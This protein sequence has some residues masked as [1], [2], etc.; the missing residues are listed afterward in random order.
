MPTTSV[1]RPT[2][3]LKQALLAVVQQAY[4][5]GGSS[6]MAVIDP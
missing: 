5:C 6:A 3:R 1:R 4:V 2:S